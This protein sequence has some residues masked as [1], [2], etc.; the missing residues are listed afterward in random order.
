MTPELLVAKT[1]T[2]HETQREVVRVVQ[3]TQILGLAVVLRNIWWAVS[4]TQE[5]LT[6]MKVVEQAVQTE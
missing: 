1:L 2:E 6:S 4:Q 3:G 5:S